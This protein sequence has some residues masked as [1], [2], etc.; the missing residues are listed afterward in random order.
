M[1]RISLWQLFFHRVHS[2]R[3][4]CVNSNKAV[5]PIFIA[6]HSLSH[7]SYT[8]RYFNEITKYF[9]SKLFSEL[10]NLPQVFEVL[11]NFHRLEQLKLKEFNSKIETLNKTISIVW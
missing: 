8:Q 7:Q 3:I 5:K 2:K 9:E 11:N 6:A 10:A 1:I 4:F